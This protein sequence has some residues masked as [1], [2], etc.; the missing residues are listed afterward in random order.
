[1]WDWRE[2]VAFARAVQP[3]QISSNSDEAR[4]RSAVSRAYYAAYHV[5]RT[6]ALANGWIPPAKKR[7]KHGDVWSWFQERPRTQTERDVGDLGQRL[8]DQRRRSDYESPCLNAKETE[9]AMKTAEEI[10]HLL[11]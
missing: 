7:E 9:S 11:P 3:A 1:V 5:A 2:Y 6:H 10:L 8:I 4:G